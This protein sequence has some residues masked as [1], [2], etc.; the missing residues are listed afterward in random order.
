MEKF[1]LESHSELTDVT[2][3]E[4]SEVST[5]TQHLA[6]VGLGSNLGDRRA[7][8]CASLTAIGRHPAIVVERVSQLYESNAIG[9]ASGIF[10][11]AVAEIRTTLDPDTLLAFLH[12]VEREHGRERKIRWG[13]RTIDLDLIWYSGNESGPSVRAN[14]P[15]PEAINRD[16]VLVPLVEL[17]PHLPLA[18]EEATKWLSRLSPSARSILGTIDCDAWPSAPARRSSANAE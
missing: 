15:H 16:F 11:N 1:G 5:S 2:G 9:A 12:E 18:G 3:L 8:L 17:T 7:I 14:L 6:Y 13:D 10:I 4:G